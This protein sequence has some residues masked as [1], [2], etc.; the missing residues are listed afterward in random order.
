MGWIWCRPTHSFVLQ[1]CVF[2]VLHLQLDMH[3]SSYHASTQR[4]PCTPP[5]LIPQTCSV[6]IAILLIFHCFIPCLFCFFCI[7]H[8]FLHYNTLWR[9]NM[10]GKC[11]GFLFHNESLCWS[12]FLYIIYKVLEIFSKSVQGCR[13]GSAKNTKTRCRDAS[14]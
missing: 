3:Q 1:S 9:E 8:C 5:G 2:K 12:T 4:G 7:L 11:A 13:K 14:V 6:C 10:S